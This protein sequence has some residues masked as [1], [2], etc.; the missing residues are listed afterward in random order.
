MT[1]ELPEVSIDAS[2]NYE[3]LDALHTGRPFALTENGVKTAVVVPYD[4]MTALVSA[5]TPLFKQTVHAVA[6]I[7]GIGL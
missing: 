1:D 3:L 4:T 5:L 7:L 2:Y 6:K